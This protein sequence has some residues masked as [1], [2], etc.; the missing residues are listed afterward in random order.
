MKRPLKIAG[1]L[2]LF[3]WAVPPAPAQ[4]N[5]V[6]PP[7][8]VPVLPPTTSPFLNLN[9]PGSS[10]AVNYYNLVRPEFEFRNDFQ[11]LQRQVNQ[12]RALVGEA[13]ADAGLPTTGH[14]TSFLNYSHFYPRLGGGFA[15]RSSTA[16][17]TRQQFQTGTRP[18]PGGRR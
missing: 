9:R 17:P 1:V 4:T 7:V 2:A 3:C 14:T 5:F 11:S 6:R 12:N 10:S 8:G 13:I 18:P 16:P 15:G